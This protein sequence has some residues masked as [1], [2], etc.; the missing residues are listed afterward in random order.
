MSPLNVQGT[1]QA[2]MG[3]TY[4]GVLFSLLGNSVSEQTGC[5]SV[6]VAQ[7]LWELPKKKKASGT[8]PAWNCANHYLQIGCAMTY[9]PNE[10]KRTRRWETAT[11]PPGLS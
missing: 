4:D 3:Y 2:R 9:P 1:E 8:K 7:A 6:R 11:G 5:D 10:P